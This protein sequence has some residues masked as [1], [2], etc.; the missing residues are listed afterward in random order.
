MC[1]INGFIKLGSKDNHS[2]EWMGNRVHSMNERI[3]HR[4]PDSEGLHTDDN[5]S[6]GM[7]RLSIID[8]DTGSQPIYSADRTKLIVF[9]GE[10]YNY[11]NLRDQL[12]AEGCVF[13]TKSDTEVVLQGIIKHGKGFINRL[14]GM[15]AF[16][17]YDS[18]SNSYLLARD[19]VGEKPLYYYK[20]DDF[21]IFG[22]ELKSLLST[23]LI[24]KEIDEAALTTYFQLAYIP[25]PMCI[26]K[27]VRKLMPSIIM[28]IDGE[29]G[30]IKTTKYW[31]L[32]VSDDE[33]YRDYDY[34]KKQLREK[35]FHSVEQRMI[36]DV[37]LGAFLS[38]GFD[39]AIIVGVMSQLSSHPIDTF[40]IG[41]KERAYDE[42]D[43]AAITAKRNGTNHHMIILD[44]DEAV[45][46]IDELLDNIDE[47]FADPSLVA[48]YVVS[49]KTKEYVTVAL[50]GDASD[51]LFA[52]YNK[53]LMGYYGDIYKRVPRVLRKTLIEPII[54]HLPHSSSLY[55][56]ASKVVENAEIPVALQ[57]KRLMSRAFSHSEVEQLIPGVTVNRLNFIKQQYE[58][59]QDV[60][61]VDDQKRLQY[62]DFHTVLEGQMLPKVDRSSMKASLETRVPML[63]REVIELAFAMPSEFKIRKRQRKIILKDAFKDMLAPELFKAPKHGF[64]APIGIWLDGALRKQLDKYSSKEYLGKLQLFNKDCIDS[65]IAERQNLN[66]EWSTKLWSFFVFQHWYERYIV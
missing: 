51:E 24:A 42:S 25:A 26:I 3:I 56:K 9:N 32:T 21:F 38:G 66:I 47:P 4:G 29:T 22:S 10:I 52:G 50:T 41:F 59:L 64:D 49:K 1:G 63:D 61:T 53:Y 11:R 30:E 62:V 19:R 54:H 23:G 34:C 7:R 27:G 57:A 8:L 46:D 2:R 55:R 5:C 18:E 39:S 16:C 31:K 14:E 37:P 28:E 20:K 35:L 6:L 43:L 17:Y 13:N 48:S 58:E 33:Q 60:G 40:T 45:K 15:F 36:A 65:V 44:W 12:I